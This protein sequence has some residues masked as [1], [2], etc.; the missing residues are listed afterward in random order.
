MRVGE[1]QGK[2]TTSTRVS[3][4]TGLMMMASQA[5]SA[6]E[7]SCRPQCLASTGPQ[8]MVGLPLW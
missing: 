3:Y 8:Q 4:K 7:R 2:D 5:G 6:D 1:A